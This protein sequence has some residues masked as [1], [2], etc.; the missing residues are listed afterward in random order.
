[1]KN[2]IAGTL[3]R[4]AGVLAA[5]AAIALLLPASPAAADSY[6]VTLVNHNSGKCLEIGGWSVQNGG[7]ADQWDCYSGNNNQR[8]YVIEGWSPSDPVLLQNVHS[9]KCLEIADWRTD[10]G[11]PAR[12]WDC[13]S[14]Q[15][16][17]LWQR[18]Q[19]GAYRNVNSGKCLEIA[20][21][22]TANGAPARQWNCGSGQA[23]QL[24]W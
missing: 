10:N 24:W 19:V 13:G 15:G 20:D 11:A 18:I 22:S 9:G 3:R 16:N 6:G 5:G 12:Q 23:N 7:G 4:A 2:S 1:M 21:W 8:F 14:G 17:Q